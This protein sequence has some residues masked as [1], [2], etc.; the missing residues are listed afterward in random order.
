MASS[1]W[2][3]AALGAMVALAVGLA[4]AGCGGSSGGGGGK[5][6]GGAGGSSGKLEIALQDDAVFLQRSYYDLDRALEQA[7]R[8]GVTRLRVLAIWNRVPGV[9][10]DARTRPAS[11]GYDWSSYDSLI[12]DAAKRGIRL[13]LDLTGP[14]PAWATGDGKPGVYRPD[15]REFGEFAA[16]AARHFKERVDRYS[17]WNEPNYV[18][19]LAPRRS[20]PRIYRELYARAYAAVKA[21]DPGAEVLIGETAPYAEPGRATAPLAFLRALTCRT[22]AYAPAARCA[23]LR[24]DGYAHHPYEFPDPPRATNAGADDVSLGGLDRLSGALERLGRAGAL[25]SREGKPLAIYL[26]EF[27]Y[28]ARGSQALPARTRARS[29]EAAFEIAARNRSVREMLQYM[30][31]EPPKGIRFDT[32]LIGMDGKPTL[33]YLRLAG[34]ARR[35][36]KDGRVQPNPGHIELPPPS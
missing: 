10:P 20:E 27:G 32:S 18:S 30:L 35:N 6:G 17:I 23:P 24:A 14:A 19:W 28:F 9:E 8:M 16:A 13:Q 11:L 34:W 4:V 31:I 33:P 1:G 15:P 12:D 25:T 22:R 21:A 3:R 7:Q 5:S 36:S 26:T 2:A 29:L